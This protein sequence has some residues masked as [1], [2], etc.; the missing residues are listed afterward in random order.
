MTL[1]LPSSRSDG[2]KYQN[3]CITKRN[4]ICSVDILFH[5]SYLIYFLT[6]LPRLISI[7][8]PHPTRTHSTPSSLSRS[9]TQHFLPKTFLID[10]HSPCR[11]ISTEETTTRTDRSAKDQDNREIYLWKG[12]TSRDSSRTQ[13]SSKPTNKSSRYQ[14][15]ETNYSQRQSSLSTE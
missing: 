7:H 5:R 13:R 4:E 10:S 9:I 6:M 1:T 8:S 12:P 3:K 14:R 15:S 2:R 11:C